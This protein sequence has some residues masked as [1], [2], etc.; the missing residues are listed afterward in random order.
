[1]TR[2]VIFR[3]ASKSQLDKWAYATANRTAPMVGTSAAAVDIVSSLEASAAASG[4]RLSLTLNDDAAAGHSD[5]KRREVD[6]GLLPTNE[7]LAIALVGVGLVA[8]VE[9]SRGQL[10]SRRDPGVTMGTV[11]VGNQVGDGARALPLQAR[12]RKIARPKPFRGAHVPGVCGRQIACGLEVGSDQG[13][14]LLDGH[15]AR[16]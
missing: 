16:S 15:W 3:A 13:R 4:T 6:R 9:R 11:H 8:D 10:G 2:S 1:M 5:R 12:G 7:T 14:V